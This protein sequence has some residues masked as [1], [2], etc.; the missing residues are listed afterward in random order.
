VKIA[1]LSALCLALSC[2]PV[3]AQ[4]RPAEACIVD[5]GTGKR[6]C[7]KSGGGGAAPNPRPIGGGCNGG[8]NECPGVQP[9][10]G[11]GVPG[12]NNKPG[13]VFIR[14]QDLKAALEGGELISSARPTAKSAGVLKGGAAASR[15][16]EKALEKSLGAK[17]K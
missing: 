14:S 3:L 13:Q 12:I 10:I 5:P 4:T 8:N 11:G 6:I 15:I 7:I 1:P 17:I 9:G 2:G 16:S